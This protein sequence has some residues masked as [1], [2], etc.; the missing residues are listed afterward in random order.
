MGKQKPSLLHMF[1]NNQSE[2]VHKY[3]L[4]L[5]TG[6]RGKESLFSND[7]EHIWGDRGMK[8]GFL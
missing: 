7:G 3:L 2:F 1:E 8:A 5:R 4:G 6:K